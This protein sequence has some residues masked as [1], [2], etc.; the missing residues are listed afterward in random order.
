MNICSARLGK[1]IP[2]I[3][4][5][6]HGHDW[7]SLLSYRSRNLH[8]AVVIPGNSRGSLPY[9][10]PYYMWFT[11]FPNL[12]DFPNAIYMIKVLRSPPGHLGQWDLTLQPMTS[13]VSAGFTIY[14]GHQL[15]LLPP[16]WSGRKWTEAKYNSYWLLC[17]LTSKLMLWYIHNGYCCTK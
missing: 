7:Q 3:A 17:A 5:C 10:W 15:Y 16:F 9:V 6:K 11:G 14:P 8:T 2:V 4:M 12:Q 13:W 1:H